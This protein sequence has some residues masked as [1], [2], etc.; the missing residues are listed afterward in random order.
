MDKNQKQALID[1]AESAV[2]QLKAAFPGNTALPHLTTMSVG[3]SGLRGVLA[4]EQAAA[5]R[6]AR[7]QAETQG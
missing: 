1:Q 7:L 6:L 2:D 3:L 5:D 4:G